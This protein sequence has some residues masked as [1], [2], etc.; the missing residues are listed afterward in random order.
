M[1]VVAGRRET[2]RTGA[3]SPGAAAPPGVGQQPGA[4]QQP[5]WRPRLDPLIVFQLYIALLVL[6]PSVYIVA[7][8]GASGT[9]ATIFGCVIFVIWVVGRLTGTRGQLRPT[10]LHW[11]VAFFVLAMLLGFAAGMLRPITATESSS[12]LRGLIAL[13]SGVGVMLFAADSLRSREMVR[14]V[15]SAA[16]LGGSLLA[17]MGVVQFVTNID[18]V[19]ILHLPG[20]TANSD[21]GGLYQRSGFRR[22]SGTAIHSIEFSAVVGLVLPVAAHFALNASRREW[23]RWLQFGV[24]AVALPLTVARS[25]AL[26]LAFGLLFVLVAATRRQRAALLATLPVVAVGFMVATPGLLGTIRSLFTGAGEDISISGRTDDLSAVLAFVQQ[27][28]LFGRGFNT[29]IPNIYRTL[30]NQYYGTAVESGLIGLA[31]LMLLFIGPIVGCLASAS[32]TRDRFLRTQ[33]LAVATGLLGA[34]LLAFTFDYLGFPM[35]FGML[36]LMLGISGAIWRVHRAER[37]GA[38]AYARRRRGRLPASGLVL[39]ALCALSVLGAGAVAVQGA[40]SVYE[41]RASVLLLVPQASDENVYDATTDIPGV[42]NIMTYLME[43]EGVRDLLAAHG[44][45][46]YSTAIGTGSLAPYTDVRG[47]GNIVWFAARAASSDQALAAVEAVRDTFVEELAHLQAGRGIPL[48][49]QVLVDHAYAEPQVYE[50]GVSRPLG[51]VAVLAVAGLSGLLA[52]L[53]VQE[54]RI[55]VARRK[56]TRPPAPTPE[57]AEGHLNAPN[58]AE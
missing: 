7:P 20:L 56:L 39:A 30:D 3:A 12:S 48:S 33:A 8:L 58:P 9:P 42:S 52:L 24:M 36:C 25:G 31:A 2:E 26:A 47:T 13:A 23:W 11:C 44:V 38:A 16:V 17:L 14:A 1:S 10:P 18:F 51:I 40:R 57:A 53:T 21:I 41:A 5:K 45:A 37:I 55:S 4:G 19:G 35:A 29:F 27:S 49:T 15:L 6:S 46:D 43:S 50:V 22:V 54:F 28:P 32:G 34:A